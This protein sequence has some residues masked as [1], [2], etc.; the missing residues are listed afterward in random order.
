MALA[1][2][3]KDA[4][5]DQ[6]RREETYGGNAQ[7]QAMSETDGFKLAMEMSKKEAGGGGKPKQAKKPKPEPTP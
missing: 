1:Q 6:K 2:S 3:A 5:M 7:Y 4:E